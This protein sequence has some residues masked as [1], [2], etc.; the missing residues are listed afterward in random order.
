MPSKWCRAPQVQACRD[1]CTRLCLELSSLPTRRLELRIPAWPTKMV[2][3][4]MKTELSLSS[5]AEVETECIVVV[6]LD[7]GEKDKPQP[8]L[9]TTDGAVQRA[10]AEVLA[11]GEV[12][13]KIFETTLLYNPAN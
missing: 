4:P 6:A 11:S 1:D 3:A 10:A 7:R 13:G 9:E 12:A 8:S 2:N 5:P